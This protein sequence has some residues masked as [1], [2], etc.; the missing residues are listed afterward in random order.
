LPLE[1]RKSGVGFLYISAYHPHANCKLSLMGIVLR[2]FNDI[3]THISTVPFFGYHIRMSLE[4]FRNNK[5]EKKP[6]QKKGLANAIRAALL[7]GV[8]L[9]GTGAMENKTTDM[10]AYAA[11]DSSMNGEFHVKKGERLSFNVE[12]RRNEPRDI[13]TA[14]VGEF[15]QD[16]LATQT[17][18]ITTTKEPTPIDP[19]M[20]ADIERTAQELAENDAQI[21][22]Y[23]NT[24]PEGLGSNSEKHRSAE[25][26]QGSHKKHHTG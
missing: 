9:T 8:V 11:A 18:I 2:I 16:G 26:K 22:N 12:D 19:S 13:D 4:S 21:G 24:I 20:A 1:A 3:P 15:I 10:P 14:Q 17:N 5:T 23:F 7:G 6:D 25:S